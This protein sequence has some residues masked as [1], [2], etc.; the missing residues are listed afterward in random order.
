MKKYILETL[1]NIIN[2]PSPSPMTI[3]AINHIKA[4]F[5][6]LGLETEITRRGALRATLKG[7]NSDLPALAFASHVDTL[8][9]LVTGFHSNGHPQLLNIGGLYSRVAEG[10]RATIH[11]ESG[12]NIRG[13]ILPLKTSGH[14]YSS[15]I[16]TQDTNWDNIYFRIDEDVENMEDSKKLGI[17]VGD[18]VSLD[19]NYEVSESGYINSRFLDD[20]AGVSVLLAYAKHM[21]DNKLIPYRDIKLYVSVTEE[22]GTGASHLIGND[23]VSDFIAVDMAVNAKGQNASNKGVTITIKD[24]GSP[25]D[26][27]LN[28]SLIETCKTNNI[29]YTKDVFK[30]YGSDT[31]TVILAG[32]DCRTALVCF[33][34]ESSHSWERTHIDSLMALT[35]MLIAFTQKDYI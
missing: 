33:A 6:K 17:D 30:F 19:P 21:K 20:K 25:Y 7:K 10:A 23:N 2:I 28:K 32:H 16:S 14:R 26:P 12:K 1:E 13:T 5:D 35:N 3:D 8:G 27:I 34:C 22:T 31:K 24:S 9:A 4:E 15:E 11:C 29:P 18:I